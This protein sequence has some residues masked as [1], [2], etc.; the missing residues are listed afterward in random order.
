MLPSFF[1]NKL[2][3]GLPLD[4]ALQ[5]AKL[6]FLSIFDQPLNLPHYWAGNILIGKAAGLEIVKPFYLRYWLQLLLSAIILG[7]LISTNI[8]TFLSLKWGT[9]KKGR[10]R[11]SF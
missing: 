10:L 4:Y 1:H 11:P 7:L 2:S 5:Q 6:V 8:R 3:Q 9:T